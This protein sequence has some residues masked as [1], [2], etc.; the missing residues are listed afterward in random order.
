MLGWRRSVFGGDEIEGLGV[1]GIREEM[2]EAGVEFGAVFLRPVADF[3]GNIG[4][5]LQMGRW[6][7]IPPGMI[8]DDVEAT[9]KQGGKFMFHVGSI[10]H[11]E[12]SGNCGIDAGRFDR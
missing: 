3:P 9:L 2:A 8:G 12:D 7:P 10:A 5:G 6:I 4:Q 1:A 11:P